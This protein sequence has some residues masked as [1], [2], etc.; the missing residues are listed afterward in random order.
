MTQ[1]QALNI[2]VQVAHSAQKGGVLTLDEASVVLQAVKTF[3][4]KKEEPAIG[5]AV[6][7]ELSEE[8]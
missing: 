7:E 5:E 6:Q 3:T 1:D 2:L 4:D 8:K